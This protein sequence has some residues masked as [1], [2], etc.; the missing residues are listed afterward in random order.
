MA[1]TAGNIGYIISQ[2]ECTDS[3]FRG[4]RGR[5]HRLHVQP[6]RM[7][8]FDFPGSSG[9]TFTGFRVFI[10]LIMELRILDEGNGFRSVYYLNQIRVSVS[11]NQG[12]TKSDFL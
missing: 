1:G 6:I 4:R 11:L 5:G 7:Y 2:S 12:P 3:I 8:G 10:K 9:F